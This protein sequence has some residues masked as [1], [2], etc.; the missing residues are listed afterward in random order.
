METQSVSQCYSG[1]LRLAT[2]RGGATVWPCCRSLRLSSFASL[3]RVFGRRQS[4]LDP[5]PGPICGKH[6]A[7]ARVR[8]VMEHSYA[9][10]A[11]GNTIWALRSAFPVPSWVLMSNVSDFVPKSSQISAQSHHEATA[12]ARGKSDEPS[13]VSTWTFCRFFW[14]CVEAQQTKSHPHSP[15][16]MQ[17]FKRFVQAAATA[18][19]G[20]LCAWPA[21]RCLCSSNRSCRS[22]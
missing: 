22:I 10:S 6:G 15:L 19:A 13:L 17:A 9:V 16:E 1:A 14:P 18:G 4:R 7:K 5:L 8:G 2:A 12:L 3:P 21:T 20:K 11:P